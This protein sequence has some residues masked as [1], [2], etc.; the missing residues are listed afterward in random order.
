MRRKAGAWRINRRIGRF[1]GDRRTLGLLALLAMITGL[2]GWLEVNPQHNPWAPLDLRH[3]IGMATASKVAALKGDVDQCRVVLERSEVPFRALVGTGEGPCERP[4]RTRLTTYPL[5]PD[6]P[7]V[8]CP[9]A[10]ALEL[11]RSKSVSPTAV[12]IFGSDLAR[13]EHLGSYSC[14][15]L[16]GRDDG[17]WSE[18]ASANAIDIAAFLLEDG[19]RISVLADW[20]GD[21]RHRRFLREVRDGACGF[22]ATV[23]SPDYNAAHGDHFHLD[24]QSRWSGVCR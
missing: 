13:I 6:T 2:A 11:W 10:A 4:D 5:A 18:H 8:T 9:L 20:N 24:Q 19:T 22:F 1:R 16:Y 23:L 3:P 21:E 12:E 15:R 17:P 7:S 14:R